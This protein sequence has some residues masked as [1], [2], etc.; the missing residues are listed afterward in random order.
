M[1]YIIIGVCII[2]VVGAGIFFRAKLKT[3]E[4]PTSSVPSKAEDELSLTAPQDETGHDLVIQVEMLPAEAISGEG[5]L[6]EITDSK[7]LARVN[8]LIPNLAQAGNAVN[9]AVQAVQAQGEV[10]YRA[11][12]PAG[13]KLTDSRGME[14]AVRGFYRGA[15]GIQGH[16]NLV[17]VEAQKGTVV[18]ANTAAAAMGVASMVVGQYYMTQINAELGQISDGISKIADF[19]DNEYRSRV[20]SLISHIKRIAE[21]QVEILENEELRLTKIAQL[22]SLEEECTQLLGQ[23][24]LTLAGF[25]KKKDLDFAAY[26][27]ELQEAQN[28]YIYQNTLLEMLYKISDLSSL[29]ILEQF[30]ESSAL[31]CCRP[32][33]SKLR[34][35][36]P[37]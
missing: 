24:N 7:V 27:K 15:D 1:E 30:P 21:F 33:L 4:T 28:W 36:S 12:I 17:A 32:I 8:N 22:D 25:A 29:C 34:K 14:G 16:A 6:V 13:A 2:A 11:I 3:T 35:L 19:Q 37:A 5:S 9:N 23:A 20:F 18:V 26:E 10:L 31:R